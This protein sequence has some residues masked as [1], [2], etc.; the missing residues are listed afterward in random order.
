MSSDNSQWFRRRLH[1]VFGRALASIAFFGTGRKEEPS[2]QMDGLV[3]EQEGSTE[4]RQ[5]D[6]ARRQTITGALEA[7]KREV[8]GNVA[9][10]DSL[11]AASNSPSIGVLE[12]SNFVDLCKVLYD[13]VSSCV[14]AL[15]YPRY[16]RVQHL[17]K[18]SICRLFK[19]RILPIVYLLI[20]SR[21]E[22]VS[23][24][25]TVFERHLSKTTLQ[26]QQN[27]RETNRERRCQ[28][29]RSLSSNPSM[30]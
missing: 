24:N 14:V 9:L 18:V 13:P 11:W 6:L 16:W 1:T 25:R 17:G 15:K 21:D 10:K 2:A 5:A 20:F 28:A 22:C 23:S 12:L 4:V 30:P 29:L 26:P 27:A 19:A 3:I 8:S 7:L